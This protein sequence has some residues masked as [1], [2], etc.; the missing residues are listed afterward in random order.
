MNIEYVIVFVYVDVLIVSGVD[1][2][3]FMVNVKVKVD[4]DFD[5]LKLWL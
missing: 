1:W 5:V 2:W 3:V 4:V